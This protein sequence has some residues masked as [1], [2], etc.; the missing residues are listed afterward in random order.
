MNIQEQIKDWTLA[1]SGSPVINIITVPEEDDDD[2]YE[3]EYDG[4]NL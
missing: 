2:D 4:I 3:D 1:R